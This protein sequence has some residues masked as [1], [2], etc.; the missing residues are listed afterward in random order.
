MPTKRELLQ[1][2]ALAL[3]GTSLASCAREPGPSLAWLVWNRAAFG[4]GPSDL[5]DFHLDRFLDEQLHPE[6]MA[7][8]P[9]QRRLARLG[10]E[11]LTKSYQD[12]WLE[13]YLPMDR[14]E[15]D[16]D[17][18]WVELPYYETVQATLVRAVHSR[19]QLR[20]VM[21]D[22]WHNHFNVYGAHDDVAPLLMAYDRD[23][24]RPHVLGN[25]HSLL[26]AVASHPVMLLYLANSSNE[27][28]GPNE[29]FA[30]ELLELHTL[31]AAHYHGSR[32]PHGVEREGELA[33]GYVDNDV[34]EVARCFTGW[35]LDESDSD[36]RTGGSG[37]FLLRPDRHDRFNKLVLGRYLRSDQ[38]VAKDVETVLEMLAH[39]PATARHIAC[40][41]CR[42]LVHDD[43]PPDL[44]SRAAR[45]F[46]DQRRAPDQIG[47]VIALI[48]RS[49]EFRH[50]GGSPKFKRPL[51]FAVSLLRALEVDF[52][53]ED[54]FVQL[55][56]AMQQPLFGRPTPDGYPDTARHWRHTSSLLHRWRLARAVI[57]QLPLGPTPTLA[58]WS[59][60]LLGPAA[61]GFDL[62]PLSRLERGEALTLLA[63]SPPF[64]WR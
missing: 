41:L 51:E 15:T 6:Q 32:D 38:G 37:Q 10:L 45:L 2:L 40:K 23:A 4:P 60:R 36:D 16:E 62:A 8:E 39:H 19:C 50:S 27:V 44:V 57:S 12:L 54:S 35:T 31:G 21:A 33:R 52:E 63:M 7:D 48:L 25:F 11:T 5:Q 43:P 22:F 55:F 47:Q 59:R 24:I 17:W 64:Q 34:Y 30:R 3:A 46:V 49:P 26:R 13:H 9:C 29:N 18:E 14:A 53:A 42:R 56:D 28:S 1:N 58:Q 20:E 61:P